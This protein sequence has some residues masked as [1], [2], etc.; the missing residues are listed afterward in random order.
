MFTTHLAQPPLLLR[1]CLWDGLS[2][3]FSGW[4]QAPQ[5]PRFVLQTPQL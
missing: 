1:V 5:T 3:L 2:V 4:Q